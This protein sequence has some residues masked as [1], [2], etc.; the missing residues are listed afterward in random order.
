[1]PRLISR[2]IYRLPFS[3]SLDIARSP[4]PFHYKE[5]SDWYAI[6][7][8]MP[9]GTPIRASLDGIVEEAEDGFSNGKLQKRFYDRCNYVCI[10][11]KGGE[12]TMYAHLQRGISVKKDDYVRAGDIIGHSGLSGFTSYPHLH[13]YVARLNRAGEEFTVL[14]RFRKRKGIITLRS[15]KE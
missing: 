13:F 15:P 12:H 9:I 6:D 4:A 14:A 8:P 3:E 5:R 7:F 2:N 11:H 1:M 10:A